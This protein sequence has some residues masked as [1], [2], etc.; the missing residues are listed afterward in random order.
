MKF[1]FEKATADLL[2][3][4]G[5]TPVDWH[6]P[7]FELQTIAGRLVCTPFENWVACKFDDEKL[8]VKKIAEG[9]LNPFSGKWNWHYADKPTPQHLAHFRSVIQRIIKE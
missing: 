4:L 8:A 6:R 5:G 9:S 3:E 7:Q 2:T 1:N